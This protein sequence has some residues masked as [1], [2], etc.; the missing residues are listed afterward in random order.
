MKALFRILDTKKNY[1]LF[2]PIYAK[3]NRPFFVPIEHLQCVEGGATKGVY[4]NTF[5]LLYRNW[6]AEK[7]NNRKPSAEKTPIFNHPL[8]L[9]PNCNVDFFPRALASCLEHDQEFLESFGDP[10]NRAPDFN[11]SSERRP[12]SY[13]FG[14]TVPQ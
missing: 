7:L 5:N 10:E 6:I 3:T 9:Q 13:N 14:H 2:S 4:S 12:Q 8:A 1:F 11:W